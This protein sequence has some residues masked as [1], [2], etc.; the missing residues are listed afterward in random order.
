MTEE[1]AVAVQTEPTVQ[2]GYSIRD[3]FFGS[4]DRMI[5]MVLFVLA[6]C[7][8]IGMFLGL[9]ELKDPFL[10]IC[11]AFAMAFNGGSRTNA[12]NGK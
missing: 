11:G 7:C 8:V 4:R 9:Q 10:T 5:I 2:L 3:S 1:S 6:I 12:T